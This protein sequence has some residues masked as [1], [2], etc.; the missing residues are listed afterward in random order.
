MKA[1]QAIRGMKDIP[2]AETP[3]WRELEDAARAVL[4]GYG[5]RELRPPVVERT[6]LFRR[7]V[8]EATDI[9]EKEMYTFDDRSGESLSLRPE[10]TAS[11][12]RAAVEHGWLRGRGQRLWHIGP[13]FRYERPQ[14]GRYRQF[15]QLDVE[16]L[17]FPGP[18]V[19]AELILIGERL[20][21][22]LRLGALRLELN[23]L[24][25]RAIQDAF[26]ARLVEYLTRH[27][28]SLDEDSRRRL[29]TNPLRILDS[30]NPD[31]Q[32]LLGAAPRIVDCLD[33]ESRE[34]FEGLQAMLEASGV[35][36]S[37]NPRLVRGLD[38]YT[39]TVFEWVT[40]ELG[41]QGAVCGGGRYDG[42]VAD[43][44]G[45]PTPATGFAVGLERVVALM[46]ARQG[47]ASDERPHAYL[48]AVGEEA[49]RT[50]HSLAEQL[51]DALPR[52]RLVVDAGPGNFKR[53]MK[54][55][56]RSEAPLALILGE[57]EARENRITLKE[58]HGDGGQ[59]SVERSQMVEILRGH[60]GSD[61]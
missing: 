34:H 20:W 10:C 43:I 35:A 60:I 7:S 36:F 22:R 59:Q 45:P 28:S 29:D 3:V 51:R 31:M 17:G 37:V 38:Y 54:N 13:M 12:V 44:G 23:S 50:A 30:K 61:D 8:G 25:S 15:H 42:L 16:A 5:Y 6:E 2:P 39:R 41:A 9:V 1:I 33:D 47:A 19:D 56:D 24:G 48:L 14:K 52:V 32:D 21:R 58:M 55:A 49:Q 46:Q 11:C 18:D 57:D 27:A 40:D 26:R 53:K 4:S